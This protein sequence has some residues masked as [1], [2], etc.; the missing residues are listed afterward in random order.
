VDISK[1]YIEM[2]KNAVEVQR[3]WEPIIGDCVK[4]NH[5]DVDII[6]KIDTDSLN[7]FRT[8]AG[9]GFNYPSYINKI[10]WLPR[11]D[12]LQKLSNNYY[13]KGQYNLLTKFYD[14]CTLFS[15][16]YDNES[17]INFFNTM[18]QLWLG[19]IM[20]ERYK[21]V[22]DSETWRSYQEYY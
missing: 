15:Y 17:P 18:E 12:Q 6:T 10:I 7:P 4:I 11:Q 5:L 1:E 20:F 22:W 2:C 13:E 19:F 8:S 16:T 21:K 9:Y 14:W 3:N